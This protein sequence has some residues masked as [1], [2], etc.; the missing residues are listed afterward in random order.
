MAEWQINA[1]GSKILL[2][3]WS[4]KSSSSYHCVQP[5]HN[6]H[7][8]EADSPQL[9]QGHHS[10]RLWKC[11]ECQSRSWENK[12]DVW[13]F[14]LSTCLELDLCLF[15]ANMWLKVNS[16]LTDMV[17]SKFKSYL[18]QQPCWWEFPE[19]EPWNPERR[20]LQTQQWSWYNCWAHTT[21]H[22]PYTHAHIN[23]QTYI[24][25]HRYTHGDTHTRTH[26]LLYR[27]K[28]SKKMYSVL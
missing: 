14:I 13:I 6:E 2:S 15:V 19:P 4:E 12:R 7:D 11:N 17:A 8:E 9:R 22:C 25:T 16:H 1:V 26:S 3:H 27:G 20:K 28:G 18:N 24:H 10:H 5:Q 21:T 23:T